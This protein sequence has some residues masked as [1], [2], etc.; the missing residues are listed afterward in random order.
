[1]CLTYTYIDRFRNQTFRQNLQFEP[2][3][4]TIAEGQLR[5]FSHVCRMQQ[6]RLTNRVYET[7]VR[8]E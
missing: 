1:M 5:W 6:N 7:S 8:G 4:D 2:I 3:N